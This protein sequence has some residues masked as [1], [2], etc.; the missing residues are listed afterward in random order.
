MIKSLLTKSILT[1]LIH[2]G[3]KHTL[4]NWN[5]WGNWEKRTLHFQTNGWTVCPWQFSYH[6]CHNT[7]QEN[8]KEPKSITGSSK[9]KYN[10]PNSQQNFHF[11]WRKKLPEGV[12][13]R[14]K[15]EE[16]VGN[17]EVMSGEWRDWDWEK[18]KWEEEAWSWR[19]SGEGDARSSDDAMAITERE[20]R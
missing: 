11:F 4:N 2:F 8:K 3:T 9:F 14:D 12:G 1:K 16:R 7:L 18:E 17:D 19:E 5:K 20:D 10:K 15:V 6:L 13:E